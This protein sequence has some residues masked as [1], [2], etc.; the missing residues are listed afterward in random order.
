MLPIAH[1]A[2]D[3]CGDFPIPRQSLAHWESR[4]RQPVWSESTMHLAQH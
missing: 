1:I 4:L 2:L 3:N